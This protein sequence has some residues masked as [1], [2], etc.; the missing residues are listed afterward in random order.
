MRRANPAVFEA[1]EAHERFIGASPDKTAAQLSQIQHVRNNS[2]RTIHSYA[3]SDVPGSSPEMKEGV[4]VR[5]SKQQAALDS[6]NREAGS[7]KAVDVVNM[8]QAMKYGATLSEV[9]KNSGFSESDQQPLQSLATEYVGKE[10]AAAANGLKSELVASAA[11]N[12]KL[13]QSE[14]KNFE[15][16]VGQAMKT[17]DSVEL[18]TEVKRLTDA[19]DQAIERIKERAD[20]A[21]EQILETAKVKAQEVISVVNQ[22][23][24]K[25]VTRAQQEVVIGEFMKNGGDVLMKNIE[26]YDSDTKQHLLKIG[27]NM[28]VIANDILK[29]AAA[30][31]T[32]AQK[33]FITGYDKTIKSLVQ[34]GVQGQLKKNLT[35]IPKTDSA[36]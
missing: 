20:K 7:E 31:R 6:S 25:G 5:S 3:L 17:M 23:N 30:D 35:S 2:D 9:L 1:M 36:T 32:E 26:K 12:E 10:A 33:E 16:Q 4:R 14:E 34:K 13:I 19:R 28:N 15:K 18:E 24:T 11:L 27:E 21:G 22:T 29:I 8:Q